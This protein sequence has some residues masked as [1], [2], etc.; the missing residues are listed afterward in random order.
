MRVGRRPRRKRVGVRTELCSRPMFI[1][2]TPARAIARQNLSVNY[3]PPGVAGRAGTFNQTECP[4][5]VS[6]LCGGRIVGR[7]SR[8]RSRVPNPTP[9]PSALL[10]R[11]SADRENVPLS[12]RYFNVGGSVK[13]EI[14]NTWLYAGDCGE[15]KKISKHSRRSISSAASAP[16]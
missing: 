14:S 1:T 15:R 16:G 13:S 7:K 9:R 8:R 11:T 10:S 12:G 2:L 3:P 4:A 6:H 5:R